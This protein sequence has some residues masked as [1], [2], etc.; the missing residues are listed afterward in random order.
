MIS[1]AVIVKT[2]G[3]PNT[4]VCGGLMG[5][6]AKNRGIRGMI[7]DGLDVIPMNWKT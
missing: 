2:G 4:P 6:L 1:G 5:G 3:G 7:V